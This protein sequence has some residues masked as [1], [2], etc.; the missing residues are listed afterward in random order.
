[1]L[2]ASDADNNAFVR[3]QSVEMAQQDLRSELSAVGVTMQAILDRLNNID[4]TSQPPKTSTET[5][6]DAPAPTATAPDPPIPTKQH[7]M[8]PAAPSEFNGDRAKG[9]AFLN[10]CLLYMTLCPDEFPTVEKRI[11]WILT[12]MKAGRAATWADRL[13]R[14]QELHGYL[15]Y[16]TWDA[17]TQDFKETFYPENE[18][19]EALMKLE[20]DHY[21]QRKRTV[22]T[23]VDEFEDLITLSGY[24]DKLAIVIKFRR[25]LS[26]A[27][28]D[29]IAEMGADRPDD[30][31]PEAWYT[32]AR[33]F[34]Q[35]RRANEA[36]HS[37]ALRRAPP[38]STIPPPGT[39]QTRNQPSTRT[40]W[41]RPSAPPPSISQPPRPLPPGIP[42]DIDAAKRGGKIPGACYRCG[43]VGHRSRDCP[44]GLDIRLMSADD[45]E[46]LL[47]DLLALKDAVGEN[48]EASE[49]PEGAGEEGFGC[50]SG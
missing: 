11:H 34:D 1:M 15:R 16:G 37:S 6:P 47:E 20:S 45:R 48:S 28:Q 33:R 23:Y 25:G 12:F 49:S 39:G 7:R 41:P 30:R 4:T 5:S 22:D 38:S 18:A 3:L 46:E 40:P 32:A 17:F 35:N 8:K 29:K 21:F 31:N 2:P 27:I 9:R 44:T 19:T 42:M 43:E 36:F 14:Y 10:S 26:P 13:M 24:S 50:R